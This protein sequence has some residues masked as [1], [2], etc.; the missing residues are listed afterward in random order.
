M[1]ANRAGATATVLGN[2]LILIAGGSTG[3]TADLFDPAKVAFVAAG[4]MNAARIRH[5]A[6]VLPNGKVLLVG[7]SSTLVGAALGS[8]SLYD[9]VANTFAPSAGVLTT[10]RYTHVAM[11]FGGSVLIAGGNT[12]TVA[13]PTAT[14][15]VEVYDPVAD[16][17]GVTTFS[18]VLGLSQTRTQLFGT[19]LLT[20]GRVLIGGG[21][22][23]PTAA[24]LIVP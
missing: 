18:G 11:V 15:T 5:T 19:V 4:A 14:A 13:A 2:N 1:Q 3:T 17:F 24:D 21:T 9:P 6:T 8:A 7:G 22:G 23:A 20:G 16:A 10:A 12:G